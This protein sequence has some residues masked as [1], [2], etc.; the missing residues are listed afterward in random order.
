VSAADAIESGC[1]YDRIA[2][3]VR[4]EYSARAVMATVESP[5]ASVPS[6][7]EGPTWSD[8]TAVSSFGVHLGVRANDGTL[9][10][11]L[12]ERLPPGSTQVGASSDAARPLGFCYSVLRQDDHEPVDGVRTDVFRYV[13]FTGST[14]FAQADDESV[15][16][17]AFEST[18]RFDVAVTTTDFVFVH[19]GVVA[20]GGAAIVVPA[21]SMHGKSE[22]AVI[23]RQGLVHPFRI[24]LS[25]RTESGSARRVSPPGRSDL[26]AVPIRLVVGTSY[27]PGAVWQPRRGSSAEALMVLFANTVRARIAPRETLQVLARAV[28]HATMLEGPRGEAET[29]AMSVLESA[30]ET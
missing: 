19:A 22:F 25:L 6:G 13:A 3:A 2:A 30:N 29:V 10:A 26:P 9:L 8:G 23:D 12:F 7:I 1:Y 17:D 14:P 20:I 27:E 16:L 4:F 5:V 21:P 15:V 11:R 18:V 28:E 24:P